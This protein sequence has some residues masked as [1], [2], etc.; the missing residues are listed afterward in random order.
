[1]VQPCQTLR[2]SHCCGPKLVGSYRAAIVHQLP[3]LQEMSPRCQRAGRD[4]AQ[5]YIDLS[6]MDRPRMMLVCKSHIDLVLTRA[7][8]L[9]DGVTSL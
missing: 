3:A 8:A 7:V 9:Q 5:A 6:H 2:R 4:L 1:M